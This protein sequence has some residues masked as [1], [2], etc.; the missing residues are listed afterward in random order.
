MSNNGREDTPLPE[1]VIAHPENREVVTF[2]GNLVV[3]AKQHAITLLAMYEMVRDL[4]GAVPR[5]VVYELIDEQE[6]HINR[7]SAHLA[8][9]RSAFG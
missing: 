2:L 8:G 1:K 7:V 3:E 6:R 4:P 9:V 5:R